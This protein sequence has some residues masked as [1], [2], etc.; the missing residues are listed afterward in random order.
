M[1][2]RIHRQNNDFWMSGHGYVRA[3]AHVCAL[4]SEHIPGI[5]SLTRPYK[6]ALA[7]RPTAHTRTAIARQPTFT[8]NVMEPSLR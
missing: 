2:A 6:H 7:Q 4:K 1:T 5:F 8:L 3:C